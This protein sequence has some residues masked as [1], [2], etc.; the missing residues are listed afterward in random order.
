MNRSGLI[1]KQPDIM[2]MVAGLRLEA[3]DIWE[4]RCCHVIRE[5]PS[6]GR[7]VRTLEFDG[8]C[9]SCTEEH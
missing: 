4:G 5:C 8:Y 1:G 2:A 6:C 7:F 9:R 3:Q